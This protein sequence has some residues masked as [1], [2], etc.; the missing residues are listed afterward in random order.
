MRESLVHNIQGLPT[1]MA[2]MAPDVPHHFYSEM[3][4]DIHIS[5]YRK[6]YHILATSTQQDGSNPQF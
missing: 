6:L 3:V 2:R 4:L 1:I 5:I